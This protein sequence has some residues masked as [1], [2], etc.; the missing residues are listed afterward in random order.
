MK[1]LQEYR[2]K[3]LQFAQSHSRPVLFASVFGVI[4]IATVLS[5]FAAIKPNSKA[6]EAEIAGDSPGATVVSD[7][8]ASGGNFL[9]FNANITPTPTPPPD[10]QNATSVSQYGITWTFDKSYPVG[11]FANGDWWVAGPVVITNITP[12]FSSGRNGWEAN[13]RTP[14]NQ[15]L[16]S[17]LENYSASR[18]PAL[19]YT[20]AANTSIV[21]GISRSG[22]CGNDGSNHYPCLTTA[23]V[24]TVL[25]SVPPD[26]GA[27]VFRPPF[28]G[29]V[30][31]LYRTTQLQTASLPSLSPTSGAIS[32]AQAARRYQRV[33]LDYITVWTGRYMHPSEN[34]AFIDN[35]SND[36]VSE[37]G[38]ELARDAAVVALRLLLNDS[39]ASKMP[40]IINYVQAG[41]DIYGMH[42]G[43]VTWVSDG[44]HMLG[45]KVTAV[46]AATLLNDP[47]MKSEI[48]NA[49][50][51]TYGDD[52]HAYTTTNAQTV[53]AMQA[54][55]YAPVLWGK[56][57]GSGEYELQQREDRGPRDCRDPIAMID[58]GEAPGESYQECC[59][60][61]G[62]K[63][64]SLATRLLPGAKAVW[65]YQ[66]FH[67][68]ADRWVGFG[69]WA[70][71]DNWN[72]L[73]RTPARNYTGNHGTYKDGGGY[74]HPFINSMWATHR[75]KAE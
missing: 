46:Y 67:D 16:D 40:A 53:A 62:M 29:T 58:G 42:N 27:T 24:L 75:S 9:E 2:T 7:T 33:Q 44:G 11:Q 1:K 56:P 61:Q 8:L 48:Q 18:V 51:A 41:I 70:S 38:S 65:N 23:A 34:Y 6:V 45:R 69:A 5:S 10:G 47:T 54:A 12:A 14:N 49:T 37:Y 28:F 22:T 64:A 59:T 52:G 71:P 3:A 36:N 31:P 55:G 73:G 21:K 63:G 50:Y 19:P 15:G 32:L 39:L 74:G 4:G 35:P 26:N 60:A 20:A 17:R 25:G 57:C 30:K 68:F 13:P 43:G 72:S 66:P